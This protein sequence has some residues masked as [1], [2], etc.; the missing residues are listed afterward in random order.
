MNVDGKTELIGL[1]GWPV[2][3]SFSPAMHNAA[4]AALGLNSVYVPLPV[5]PQNLEAA[6]RGLP[7]LGF[8]GVNVTVPHKQTIMPFLD[9][10]EPGAKIIGAINTVVVKRE[11]DAS[12]QLEGHNTD[13]LGFLADLQSQNVDIGQR[14]CLILGAG[15]SARAVVYGLAQ[16]GARIHLL[17]RRVAQAEELAADF[18][19]VADIQA[20]ALTYL[21][22][23]AAGLKAPLI[24]N[25]TP[26]GMTPHVESSIWPDGLP[27]PDD[28]FVYDLV[29][30]PLETRLMRQAKAAGCQASNG[31][32]MLIQQGALAFK[33]WMGQNPNIQVMK[34]ALQFTASPNELPNY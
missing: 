31:L 21:S 33:L 27:L 19:T 22:S 14:D 11:T 30:N 16:A 18:S 13:W 34:E 28:S 20:N 12:W 10:I 4:A 7:A 8:K 26:V 24:V 32:G 25:T 9:S 15:G 3:H 5:H 29:Y 17:A 2:S 1:I 6:V 23:L